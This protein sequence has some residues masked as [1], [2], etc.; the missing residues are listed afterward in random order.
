[1]LLSE[2]IKESLLN[3]NIDFCGDNERL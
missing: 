3:R 1:M 2:K